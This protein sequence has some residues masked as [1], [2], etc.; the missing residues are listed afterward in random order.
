[1]K[2]IIKKSAL[3]LLLAANSVEAGSFSEYFPSDLFTTSLV[4]LE[5][6]IPAPHTLVELQESRKRDEQKDLVLVEN[7]VQAAADTQSSAESEE[8]RLKLNKLNSKNKKTTLTIVQDFPK[9]K[10]DQ[11]GVSSINLVQDTPSTHEQD[12]PTTPTAPAASPF[13]DDDKSSTTL[14]IGQ[15]LSQQK[16]DNNIAGNVE[17]VQG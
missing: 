2:S 4:M 6:A 12:K 9:K 3:I 14:I 8:A 17:M 7:S 1:M 5:A 11:T 10:P 16:K 13:K 15:D